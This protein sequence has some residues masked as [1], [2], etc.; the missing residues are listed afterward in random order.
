M[1]SAAVAVT[2]AAWRQGQRI[3]ALAFGL[4]TLIFFYTIGVNIIE[5]P[6]G[7]QIAGLFILGIII[8]SLISRVVRST[9]LRTERIELDATALRFVEEASRQGKLRIIANQLDA[10][11][12]AE[13][14]LKEQEVRED[15]HIPKDDPVLFLEVTVCDPSDFQ[16]VM[17]IKGVEVGGYKV[18]RAES[19]A[20]PN[21]IAAF[22][23]WVR[24]HTQ[25]I[26]HAYFGWAEG[27][28][29]KYLLRFV[30]FGEGD[31]APVTHEILRKAERDPERRPAVHVGG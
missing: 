7:L 20:V 11:D 18:L 16:D 29:I 14:R 8:T 30:V 25:K 1:G 2:L 21:A 28:P 13:Y 24:D 19:S 6:E 10:G 17:E 4:V 22:L 9:E 15:T 3:A 31:I 12:V 23:L 26:P 5:R 27:N